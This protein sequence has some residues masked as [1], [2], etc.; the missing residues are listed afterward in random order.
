MHIKNISARHKADSNTNDKKD[1]L[2]DCSKFPLSRNPHHR[3]T[4]RPISIVNLLT[5]LQVMRATT[6]RFMRAV[7][8]ISK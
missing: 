8:L 3:E 7:E 5:G 4:S 6:K 1:Y 2:T